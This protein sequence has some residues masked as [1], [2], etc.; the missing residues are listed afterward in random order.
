MSRFPQHV[1]VW[2]YKCKVLLQ[3]E[4][5]PWQAKVFTEDGPDSA[6]S[7]ALFQSQ[8]PFVFPARNVS[9]KCM[10]DVEEFLSD[11]NSVEPKEYALR[12]K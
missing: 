10:Q 9:L 2:F 3:R 6:A 1:V 12:S 7:S 5:W 4:T 11:L 8:L